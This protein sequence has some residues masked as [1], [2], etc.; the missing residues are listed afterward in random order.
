V[1]QQV[2]E[3]LAG[4][5]DAQPARVGEVRLS[6]LARTVRL[7]EKHF[8]VRTLLSSPLLDPPLERAQLARLV[9]LRLLTQQILEQG[10]RLQLRR[11][12]QALGDPWPVRGERIRPSP[13]RPRLAHLRRQLRR[14]H[15]L[16]G[17]FAVHAGPQRGPAHFA[18]LAHLLH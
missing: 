13:P 15:V 16:A 4:D 1:A 5:R 14:G 11:D 7:R 6:C 17:R 2:R 12:R 10:P 9:A 3:R 18:V 8:L